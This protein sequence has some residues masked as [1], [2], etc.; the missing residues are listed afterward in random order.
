MVS[1]NKTEVL[2]PISLFNTVGKELEDILKAQGRDKNDFVRFMSWEERELS[3]ITKLLKSE[4]KQ[5]A[6]YFGISDLESYLNNFQ[7]DYKITEKKALASYKASKTIFNK[8]KRIPSWYYA[9]FNSGM[10]IL[11]DISNFFGIED[12][13]KIFQEA[14]RMA[15]LYRTASFVP[16]PINLFAWAKRG[17]LDF[18]KLSLADYD[19]DAFVEWIESN[20]WKICL[21]NK[22]FFMS[23]PLIFSK[24][25]VGL[26]YTP[27]IEK[28]VYGA[29]RWVSGKPFIQ[30]SDR[31][32]S[33]AVCLHTL[34]H[35]IGHVLL[36]E[37]DVIFEGEIETKTATT[38]KEREAN[39]YAYQKLFNGDELR[40]YIFSS[41]TRNR[42]D[43]G[44]IEETANK[45]NTSTMFVA[46][47]MR[48][49]QIPNCYINKYIP[50]ITFS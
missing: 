5:I 34:F 28:T 29:I 46:Y 17:E 19:K 8:L 42:T 9:E 47:W 2:N 48:L 44:F 14:D 22:D 33:L 24:F 50:S 10:D 21:S 31:N 43:D 12:E 16:D 1:T 37:N 20:E 7:E 13:S 27:Y 35:E 18:A 36:H 30:I 6:S 3:Q 40:K 45:F 15:A 39:N 26:V 11:E 38:K 23:F 4:I 25:G 41:H 32:K 49:A